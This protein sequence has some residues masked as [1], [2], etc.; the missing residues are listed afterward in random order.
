[1]RRHRNEVGMP[2]GDV[3]DEHGRY[4]DRRREVRP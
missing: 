3:L 2:A 1:M 4:V